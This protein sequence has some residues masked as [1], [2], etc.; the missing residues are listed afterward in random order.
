MKTRFCWLFVIAVVALPV[1]AQ[2]FQLGTVTRM[3]TKD[4]TIVHGAFATV[5]GSVPQR[6]E[7]VCPEYTLVSDKVVYVVV[8]KRS[9]QFMPL[10]E[11][12]QFRLYKNELL[13]RIDDEKRESRFSIKEMQLRSDWERDQMLR[14]KQLELRLQAERNELRRQELKKVADEHTPK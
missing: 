4:C 14:N 1:H 8:G 13:V 2:R 11:V 6:T 3:Q 7:E 9:S 10:A 5:L 12:I